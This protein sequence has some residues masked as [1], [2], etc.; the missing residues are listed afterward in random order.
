MLN[1]EDFEATSDDGGPE[2]QQ[3]KLPL[4]WKKL[5]AFY[6]MRLMK[7]SQHKL[8]V[9]QNPVLVNANIS[10]RIPY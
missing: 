10:R 9:R 1:A 3:K 4:P 7:S 2:A 6:T 8:Q 5:E